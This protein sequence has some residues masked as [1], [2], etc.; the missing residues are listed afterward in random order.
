MSLT[1]DNHIVVETSVDEYIL[2]QIVSILPIYATAVLKHVVNTKEEMHRRHCCSHLR[3]QRQISWNTCNHHRGIL[4]ILCTD[5][6]ILIVFIFSTLIIVLKSVSFYHIDNQ[7]VFF[8]S[9]NDRK[10]S[11]FH[12][13]VATLNRC[14]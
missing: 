2:M 12:G 10:V 7:I 6:E 4:R 13:S 3:Q 11:M 9:L 1:D 8:L 5:A 14:I